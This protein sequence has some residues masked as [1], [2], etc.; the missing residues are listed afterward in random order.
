[1][2]TFERLREKIT[3]ESHAYGYTLTVWAS[4]A[5][6]LTGGFEITHLKVLTY[7]FGA[8][9]GFFLLAF[10]AFQKL[11]AEIEPTD[12]KLV[13]VSMVHLLAAIGTVYISHILT[14]FFSGY[15]VFFIIGVNA[16]FT[17][18]ILLLVEDLFSEF[19]LYLESRMVKL[20]SKK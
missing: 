16:T 10:I 11:L 13:V 18:N 2:N 17:F 7:V 4:G 3:K 5:L 8:V 20:F 12:N 9:F 19:L 14:L 15:L 6:L 1:M